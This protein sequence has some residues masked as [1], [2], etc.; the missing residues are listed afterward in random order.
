MQHDRILD[1]LFNYPQKLFLLLYS[2][3]EEAK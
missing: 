1:C 3:S 2:E